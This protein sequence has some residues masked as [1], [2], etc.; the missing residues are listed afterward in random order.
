MREHNE[1][2]VVVRVPVL[3]GKVESNKESAV[4]VL[5]EAVKESQNTPKK[6]EHYAKRFPTNVEN[7]AAALNGLSK[8]VASADSI[9][10]V[11]HY[12]S[13]EPY[14]KYEMACIFADILGL[15]KDG[16]IA[17]TEEPQGAAAVSRPKDCQLSRKVF[18][19]LKLGVKEDVQFVDFF[20]AYLV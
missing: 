2:S 8:W 18:D 15:S 9:T 14:T 4:N 20:K 1:R 10:P 11:V 5:I 3:Y 6:M 16:L 17:D 13:T 12:T 7:V 19:G